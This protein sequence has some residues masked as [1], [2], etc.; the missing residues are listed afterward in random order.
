MRE[1]DAKNY[2]WRKH[3]KLMHVTGNNST[4][5]LTDEKS[6]VTNRRYTL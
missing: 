2:G 3:D 4:H 6:R 5:I 1:K